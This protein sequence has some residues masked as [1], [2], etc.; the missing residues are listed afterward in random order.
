[1]KTSGRERLAVQRTMTVCFVD[2]DKALDTLSRE[3][4]AA[5]AK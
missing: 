3:I 1:M 2:L 4:V 5:T